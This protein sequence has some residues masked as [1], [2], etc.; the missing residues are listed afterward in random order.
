MSALEPPP[1][2]HELEADFRETVRQY[3]KARHEYFR[4]HAVRIVVVILIALAI[5]AII[6]DVTLGLNVGVR[7]LE[8]LLLVGL[9]IF[10]LRRWWWTPTRDFDEAAAVRVIERGFPELGQ[11]LRTACEFGAGHNGLARAM[12]SDA[13]RRMAEVNPAGLI[14]HRKLRRVTAIFVGMLVGFAISILVWQEFRVAAFRLAFPF[15]G[16]SFTTI[17]IVDPPDTFLED[18]TPRILARTAGRPVT[19]ATLHVREDGS[20]EWRQV[21]M[22][23]LENQRNFD[24]IL[25]GMANNF[26]Y[27]VEAGDGRSRTYY[28]HHLAPPKI[29]SAHVELEYPEYT[30]LPP[31][32]KDE[33]DVRAVEGTHLRATFRV[34]RELATASARTPEGREL[35]LE[36]KGRDLVIDTTLSRGKVVYQLSGRDAAGLELV[37]VSYKLEGLEDRLPE[38]KLV[39]PAEDVTAT[40]VWE[41]VARLRATDDFGVSGV[42]ILLMV[43]EE[44][45]VVAQRD[46]EEKTIRDVSEVGTIRLEEFPLT[47]NDNLKLFAFATD[48]KPRE[49][50]ARAVS[51]LRAIDIRQFKTRYYFGESFPMPMNSAQF[52]ALNDLVQRQRQVVS[53]AFGLKESGDPTEAS[54]AN[55]SDAIGTEQTSVR[56]D[57]S[58]LRD[59]VEQLGLM[60]GDDFILLDIAV[61][62][63]GEAA[64]HFAERLAASA[65]TQ[66][67][68]ALSSLLE[69]RKR[70]IRILMRNQDNAQPAEFENE[71]IPF[72]T[73]SKL[74][75]EAERLANEEDDVAKQVAGIDE[76]ALEGVRHQQSATIVDVG[77]LFAN[78]VAHPEATELALQ[79]IDRAEGSMRKALGIIESDSPSGAGPTLRSAEE[80]LRELAVQL[81]ALD[82]TRVSETL[83]ELADESKAAQKRLENEAGNKGKSQR[84]VGADG[85]EMNDENAEGEQAGESGLDR[86]ADRAETV[87]DVL[88]S[89]A[90]RKESEVADALRELM[91][92]AGT[93]SLARDIREFSAAS[94]ADDETLAG[95]LA[96]RFGTLARGLSEQQRRMVQGEI[97]RL[98]EAQ[99]LTEKLLA[100]GGDPSALDRGI[101]AESGETPG[102]EGS[103]ADGDEHA[104]PDA[105]DS[106]GESDDGRGNSSGEIPGDEPPAGTDGG[107]L[108]GVEDGGSAYVRRLKDFRNEGLVQLIEALESDLPKGT[109][110]PEHLEAVKSRL[111]HMINDLLKHR[112]ASS[113]DAPVPEEY[114]RMVEEY[115][116]ALSDELGSDFQTEDVK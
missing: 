2:P 49:N 71:K 33:G 12:F 18:E 26:A 88:R 15:G 91:N 56:A 41:I 102:E 5:P 29:E 9:A 54:F 86:L 37:P 109:F 53:R 98:A 34:N 96:G 60:G 64:G 110:E 65:Y 14:D 22:T 114:T 13:R 84:G 62:Q 40:S 58:D 85:S 112:S 116:R 105:R 31:E 50:G 38:V 39:E 21:P 75:D 45:Q 59:G 74:A 32:R 106:N 108:G 72:Q 103:S 113:R 3:R 8:W 42:G 101:G 78:L 97:E 94:G 1:L 70:I 100:E 73:M 115:Y 6:A 16:F 90:G 27:F 80:T 46:I 99:A 82:D 52:A 77:E 83:A 28:M 92:A 11:R 35:P 79:R 87:D 93:D 36:R 51:E 10:L 76:S 19:M 55:M 17:T 25:P 63:M 7:W 43:G 61:Q 48:H 30:G 111:D 44:T 68:R 95:E 4:K 20:A 67:D 107:Q 69:L 104:G 66:A 57:A 23:P 24:A 89:L 47:I 81:R